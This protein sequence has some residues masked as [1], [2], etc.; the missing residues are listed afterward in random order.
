[1]FGSPLS[2]CVTSSTPCTTSGILSSILWMKKLR[3]REVRTFALL[4]QLLSGGIRIQTLTAPEA[5]APNHS[6]MVRIKPD[7]QEALNTLQSKCLA[8]KKGLINVNALPLVSTHSPHIYLPSHSLL[9]R[10]H[11]HNHIF[12]HTPVFLPTRST[13]RCLGLIPSY[14]TSIHIL[15]FLMGLKLTYVQ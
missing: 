1:M 7:K 11:T 10:T 9:P 12:T 4:N 13:L 14:Q 3:L 8:P 15:F 6:L 5:Y 2:T